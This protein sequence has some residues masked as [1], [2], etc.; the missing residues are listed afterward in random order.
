VFGPAAAVG[1]ALRPRDEAMADG[2]VA[3]AVL[4]LNLQGERSTQVA[5]RLAAFGV[6]FVFAT[7]HGSNADID[8]HSAAP[9]PSKP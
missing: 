5:G 4:D 3:S 6:P 8:G 9:M 2:R 1:E 7:G